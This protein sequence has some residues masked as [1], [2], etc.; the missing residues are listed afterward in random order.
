MADSPRTASNRCDTKTNRLARQFN[1]PRGLLGRLVGWAM[2]LKNRTRVLWTIDQLPLQPGDRVLEVGCGPGVS[3]AAILR[4]VGP[5]G[6]VV[7][8][9]HSAIM[10]N[11]ARRRNAAAVRSSRLNLV[12]GDIQSIDPPA[13]DLDG[14]LLINTL[15]HA[16]DPESLLT[17][18]RS[19][20]R[21]GGWLALAHQPI[22]RYDASQ[23][24]PVSLV[25]AQAHFQTV[26]PNARFVHQQRRLPGNP[27]YLLH[28][29]LP[30]G[31]AGE[32]RR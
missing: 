3:L 17:L 29:T 19:M 25:A 22:G 10:I 28:I 20:L 23:G 14:I 26:Q 31:P 7:G 2:V 24:P 30:G 13:R 4:R 18:L 9:D 27:V 21:P 8:V 6:Y 32:N 16:H 5:T 15:H 12:H 1:H 11:Q